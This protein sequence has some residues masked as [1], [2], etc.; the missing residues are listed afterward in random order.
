MSDSGFDHDEY[1][2][3]LDRAIADVLPDEHPVHDRLDD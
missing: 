2:R 3:Q 1:L